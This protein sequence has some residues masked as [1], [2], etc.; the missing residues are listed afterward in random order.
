[1][2]ILVTG[3][4]GLLG[5]EVVT[6]VEARGLEVVGLAREDLD[7]TDALAVDAML[8]A[9]LPDWVIHCAAYTA[10][11]LAE[12]EAELA[13]LVNRDGAGNV[14]RAAAEVD[15]RTVYISTDYVF[16]GE[17]CEPYRPTDRTGPLSVY[18]RTKLAGEEA[19]L[20]VTGAAAVVGGAPHRR[21]ADP[22]IIRTGWLYGA[23]GR[24]FVSA[25]LNRAEGGARLRVVEDQ[26]GRPTWARN[27]AGVVLDL[28][29]EGKGGVW[30]VA[31]GGDATWLDFG[32]EVL[33]CRGLAGAIDGVSTEAWGAVAPR[34]AYSVMDLTATEQALGRPMMQWQ[35]A[36]A[37]FLDGDAG[38]VTPTV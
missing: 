32:R 1:M 31:D 16:D 29:A 6:A 25:I 38:G 12:E 23:G 22:L 30:H 20:T 27:L 13:M 15:A 34:P 10:V 28:V 14:A 26:R 33:R 35:A 9:E 5:T 37:R 36:L 18:G 4:L 7:V 24:N 2:K 19:V 17:Q 21:A 11:D 8:A 3:A